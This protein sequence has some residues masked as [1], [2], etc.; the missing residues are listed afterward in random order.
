MPDLQEG[1]GRAPEASRQD[2]VVGYFDVEMG[3][4]HYVFHHEA[5]QDHVGSGFDLGHRRSIDQERLFYPDLG[6]H[7]S[8]EV[9][10]HL[11]PGGG[12]AAR[13]ASFCDFRQGCA[14]HFQVL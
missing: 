9:G 13:C 3:R 14:V 10:R 4:Y 2:P 5:S 7:L 6:E 12:G 1:Q 8:R 11:Y